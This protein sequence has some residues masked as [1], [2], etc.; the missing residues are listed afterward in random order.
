MVGE[1]KSDN[2]LRSAAGVCAFLIAMVWSVFGQTL[3]YGFVNFDDGVYVYKNP[4]VASGLTLH[5]LH[6]AFTRIHPSSNWHPLTT[7]SHM[8]DCQLFGLAASGHHFVNVLLHTI[9]VLL[10]FLV[11]GQITGRLWPSA[12][13]AAVFAIH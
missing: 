10:L 9:S 3:G 12:F 5:G 4:V 1:Q 6:W 11:L 13:V 8:L 7:I 2:C